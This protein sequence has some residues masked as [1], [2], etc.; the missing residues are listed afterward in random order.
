[1]LISVFGEDIAM[2]LIG[3]PNSLAALPNSKPGY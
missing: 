1:M 3:G 2:F